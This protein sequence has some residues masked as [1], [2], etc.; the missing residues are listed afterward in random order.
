M[1]IKNEGGKELITTFYNLAFLFF[2]YSFLGW[3]LETGVAAVK[4]KHFVNRGLVN[5]PFCIIYGFTTCVVSTVYFELNGIWLFIVS[6]IMASVIEWLAGHFI[7]KLFHERWWDY[8]DRKWHLDGYICL[9]MTALW[10]ILCT[11]AVTWGNEIILD[12]FDLMPSFVCRV[13][14]LGLTAV[15][16]LDIVATMILLSGRSKNREKWESV[17]EWLDSISSRLAKRVY[18][19]VNHRITKAY[20]TAVHKKAEEKQD[21]FAYG[22]GFYKI[23]WLFIVGAFLG[24]ITETIFC[25]VT[26]GIWMSRSSVVWGPFSIVWGG[27]IAAATILLHKYKDRSDRYIFAV[28]TFLGGA[29]EY[30]CSVFSE[31]VFGKVFWDYSTM[32]FNLGGRINLL[33]CFF[34]GLAAVVWIK[35]L[36]PNISRWIEKIPKKVGVVSTWVLL[37]FMCVNMAVSGLALVRADQRKDG[38]EATSDWQKVLDERFGD[39]RLERIYPNATVVE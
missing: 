3:I 23:V 10:G 29:Y 21:V 12:V 36:Y 32:P 38:I 8:S 35:I 2:V 26:A 28:G 22:C 15:V 19:A 18:G 24:D 6:A 9:G 5:G 16:V 27:A 7:E 31:I 4:Q 20:P 34:W 17:D 13:I 11:F 37:V 39:E 33:Y 14:V 1:R 30:F 25:R